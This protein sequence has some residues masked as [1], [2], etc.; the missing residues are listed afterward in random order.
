MD[1]VP[2][3]ITRAL[4]LEL[5][6]AT[7]TATPLTAEFCYDQSDPYA[8]AAFFCAGETRVRWIFSRDLLN[9]GVHQP[10]GDGDVYIWPSIDS[11][12]RAATIIELASPDGQAVIQARTEEL[13]DFLGNTEAMVPTGTEGDHVDVEGALAQIL[14]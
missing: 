7:G 1:T 9:K 5:I 14:A 3:S 2:A 4:T 11:Y 10:T 6:D 12:G 13:Y 8:V